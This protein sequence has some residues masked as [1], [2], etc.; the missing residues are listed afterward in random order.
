MHRRHLLPALAGLT[1]LTASAAS[2]GQT[3]PAGYPSDYATLIASAKKEGKVVI[4]TSTDSKQAAPLVDA[5]KQTYPGIDV[6]VN[7]LGTNGSYNRAI[8]EAAAKQVGSDLVW[9]SAM[10]LQMVMV[11]KGLADAY[12]S[13]ETKNLPTWGHYKDLLYGTTLEPSAILYNKK[14]FP[15][16]WVPKSRAELMVFLI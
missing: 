9:T 5:F 13:P 16:E 10:D 11:E 1:M 14:L 8:S 15:A 3:A 7:D 2:L 4:Y 12:A 6:E